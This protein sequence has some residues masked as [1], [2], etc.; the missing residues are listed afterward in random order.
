MPRSCFP[1][2]SSSSAR[3]DN[4]TF[5]TTMRYDSK[6]YMEEASGENGF[7][8]CKYKNPHNFPFLHMKESKMCVTAAFDTSFLWRFHHLIPLI[9]NRDAACWVYG[10]MV[11]LTC[12][13]RSCR[14]FFGDFLS[15]Q[16]GLSS[17]LITQIFNPNL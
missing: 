5:D 2:K 9:F 10:R 3:A 4:L 8:G 11:A 14:L 15:L 13:H 7:P 1:L 6:L 17:V 12:D 16:M